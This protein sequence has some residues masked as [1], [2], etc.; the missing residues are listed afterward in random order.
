MYTQE[1]RDPKP[2]KVIIRMDPDCAICRAP[3]TIACDCEARGLEMA[4]SQAEKRMMQSI[5]DDIKYVFA[6]PSLSFFSS[7]DV[8]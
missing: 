1:Y 4:I 7:N 8:S 6:S 3:A 5:Y 2:R